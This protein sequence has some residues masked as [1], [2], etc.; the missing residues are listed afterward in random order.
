MKYLKYICLAAL[1]IV[2]SSC[3]DFLDKAPDDELTLDMV[4]KDKVRT[5]GWLANCYSGIP[6]AYWGLL[7]TIGYDSMSDDVAPSPRWVQWSWGVVDYQTGNWNTSTGWGADFWSGLPKRIREAYIF[8]DHVKPD[9]AQKVTQ[10]RV[11]LMKNEARFL[12]AYYYSIMIN[13]YGGVPKYD[14]IVPSDAT[15]EELSIGQKPF[16][17]MVD[18]IDAE[19]L[20]LSTKLPASHSDVLDYGRATSIMCLAVRARMLLFA[21]SPLVNGNQDYVSENPKINYK[22]NKGVPIFNT[23]YDPQKWVRAT[24]ACRELIDAAHAAGHELYKEYNQDGTIDPFSSYQNMMF[25]KYPENK[26]ILFARPGCDYGQYDAHATPR[27]SSGNGGLGV[28]QSLVDAFFMKN[29]LPPITGYDAE[30]KPIINEASGYSENGFSTTDEYRKTKWIEGAKDADKIPGLEKPVTQTGT[31]NMYCNREPRFYISVLY[32]GAWYRID[33]RKTDFLS[34]HKDGG[35]THDAPQNGY[36]L[37][38]K[39]SPDHNAKDGNYPYRPGILYRL[40]E[41]Y[42]NYAEA[43]NESDPGNPEIITYV[44]LIRERAGVP[45]Y[46]SESGQIIPPTNQDEVRELIR[47]ERR[48]ELNSEGGIRYNDLRRWKLAEKELNGHFYGM[49]FTG[50]KFSDDP[51]D[52]AAFFLRTVT[53]ERAYRKKNYWY[54][55]YQT[56]IDK[57]PS[58]T[59]GPYWLE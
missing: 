30:H 45:L 46:G 15:L 7:N 12:I 42:L 35:P 34:G 3:A 43:L 37:R 29:G 44:N 54:P 40:G 21:A 33:S 18:W 53:F 55:V 6:D 31:Y 9:V 47:R 50:T 49:N 16:D 41:A 56:E 14:G 20:D 36:L 8:I 52:K 58:L 17:E 27:G 51:T 10:E 39:V 4:F 32:N 1:C 23:T 57:D 11:D 28:T 13:A 48:V 38:K 26:E 5:E 25:K 59:Q 2:S 24:I 19:L 22:N